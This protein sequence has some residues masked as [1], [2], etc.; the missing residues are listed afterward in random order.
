MEQQIIR[1]L[2][3]IVEYLD[4]EEMHWEESGK[5]ENHI[6]HDVQNLKIV[7][8][9]LTPEIVKEVVLARVDQIVSEHHKK[10]LISR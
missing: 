9:S 2:H 6:F 8:H 10:G 4:C 1:S 7:A 5:P 3:K